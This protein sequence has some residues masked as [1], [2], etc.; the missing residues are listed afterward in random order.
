[1][2]ELVQ[3]LT[4]QVVNTLI[5]RQPGGGTFQIEDI[6]DQVELAWMRSG[7]HDVG[8]AY[9]L[10]REK[11]A[12]ERAAASA[13]ADIDTIHITETGQRRTLDILGLRELIEAAGD[14][15]TEYVDTNAILKE[16]V[17]NLYEGVS[18]DEVFKS[19]ILAARA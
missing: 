12:Q 1:V 3:R 7:E 6:Q 14:G 10:Y 15:L 17:R 18:L 9:V 13:H 4:T 8:R 5:R 19:A 16:T 2:R 11:R